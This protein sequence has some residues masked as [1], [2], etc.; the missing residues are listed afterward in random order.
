MEARRTWEESSARM[1]PDEHWAHCVAVLGVDLQGED[2]KDWAE[3]QLC[4]TAK[5]FMTGRKVK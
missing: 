1:G 3:A 2:H 5:L 4:L